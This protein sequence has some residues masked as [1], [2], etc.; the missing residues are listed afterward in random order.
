MSV[1][2]G[3]SSYSL[4]I[5]FDDIDLIFKVIAFKVEYLLNQWMD[6]LQGCLIYHCDTLKS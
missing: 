2:E 1:S 6:F 5:A 4:E 3:F